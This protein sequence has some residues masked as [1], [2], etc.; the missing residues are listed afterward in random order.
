M[1]SQSQL[2]GIDWLM[3]QRG[4]LWVKNTTQ[5]IGA[6]WHISPEMDIW[7]VG[8]KRLP[9]PRRMVF[10]TRTHTCKFL[11]HLRLSQPPLPSPH[12]QEDCM[13]ASQL[14]SACGNLKGREVRCKGWKED[15]CPE[16]WGQERVCVRGREVILWNGKKP[17]EELSRAWVK[18]LTVPRREVDPNYCQARKWWSHTLLQSVFLKLP[19]ETSL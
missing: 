16:K 13:M 2:T 14:E 15:I 8:R 5:V 18:V 12:G 9:F 7:S 3:A 10:L 6:H 11:L 19:M 1:G 17:L 4:L